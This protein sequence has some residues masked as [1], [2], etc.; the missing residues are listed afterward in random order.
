MDKQ[1]ANENKGKTPDAPDDPG[2]RFMELLKLHNTNRI[3]YNVRKWETVKFFQTLVSAAIAATVAALLAVFSR[4]GSPDPGTM[5]R[6]GLAALPGIAAVA[7]VLAILNTVR[8]S[9]LLFLEELQMFK[10]AKLLGLDIPIP[11]DRRWLSGDLY[12]LP[13]KWRDTCYGAGRREPPKDAE[14]WLEARTRGH[15]FLGLFS[16]L[17]LV[18]MAVSVLLFVLCFLLKT[19]TSPC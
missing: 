2:N 6:I 3:D 5:L 8:E 16:A 12:L 19:P 1:A 14:T 10:L 7:S 18:E 13:R 9:R 4:S 15:G 11:E 17:F